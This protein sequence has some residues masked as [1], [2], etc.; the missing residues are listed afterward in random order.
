MAKF[1][2]NF[3]TTLKR[4][5]NVGDL[6]QMWIWSSCSYTDLGVPKTDTK[7]PHI[8]AQSNLRKKNWRKLWCA[9]YLY[10]KLWHR[11][12]MPHSWNESHHMKFQKHDLD[13]RLGCWVKY[14]YALTPWCSSPTRGHQQES[15]TLKL[16]HVSH[17]KGNCNPIIYF[18]WGQCLGHHRKHWFLPYT[19]GSR[20]IIT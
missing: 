20:P 18:G 17:D 7:E 4:R 13:K 14:I 15:M 2:G 12:R 16:L 6:A 10:I 19:L 1:Q 8:Q 3:D 11:H 9:N 5:R